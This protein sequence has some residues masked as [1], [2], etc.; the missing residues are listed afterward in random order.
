MVETPGAYIPMD[1]LH[2]LV[3]GRL[4][5]DRTEG[6]ALFADISGFTALTEALVRELGPQRGAEELSRHLNSVYDALINTLHTYGGS[7][8]SFS[9]DAITCWFDKLL[10]T[11]DEALSAAMQVEQN[12][13]GATLR[14]TAC[15]LEMQAAMW[16]FRAVPIPSQQ[17]VALAMKAT[18]A[19]GSVRRFQIGDSK[20]QLIDAL[21]GALL[22]YLA[23]AEHLAQKGEVLL[24]QDAATLIADAIA[25]TEWRED[26]EEQRRSAVVQRLTT[27]VAPTPWPAIPTEQLSENLVRPW[28]LP[29][30]YERLT[31]GESTFLAELRPAVALFIRFTG[32]DYDN[33]DFAGFKLDSFILWVQRIL[34]RYE[35]YLLQLTIGDKGSYLCTV[36]GAPIAHED[37]AVRAISA[38]LDLQALTL[39]AIG[40][41]QI[42]I[43]TGQ[44]RTGAYGG[45]TRR[46]YGILGDD[47][48]LAARLMQAANGGHI[49]TSRAIYQAAPDEFRWEP[50]PPIAV[51]GK[52]EPIAIFSPTG[53]RER[54]SLL[55]I[56]GRY[57]LA[58]VGRLAELALIGERLAAVQ[59]QH[60]QLIGI[61]AEA[62][63]GKSRLVAEAIRL[64]QLRLFHGFGG[65]CESY[66]TTTSY[67]VWRSIWRGFFGV[68]PERSMQEQIENVAQHL[69]NLDAALLPR[70]PLLGAVLNIPIRDNELTSSFDA[71]LRKMSLEGLLVDAL[72]AYLREQTIPLLLV[73]EDCQWMD[74]LS[75]DLLEVIGRAIT[76]LPVLIIMAY[77]PADTPNRPEVPIQ[78]L[79]YF[80]ELALTEFTP[81][82]SAQLI[83]LKL[84]RLFGLTTAPPAALVTNLTQRTQGNPFYIEELLNYLHDRNIDPQNTAALARLELPNSLQSL[85]LSRIDQLNEDHRVTLRIASVIGRLFTS[86]VLW[87]VHPT[88]TSQEHVQL[89]LL[90]LTNSE[91]ILPDAEPELTYLFKHVV[92]QEVAYESLPYATRAH[93]HEQIGDFL[94]S[95]YA[96]TPDQ[97]VY[98]LAHHYGRSENEV[99]QRRYFLRAGEL[100]Q[101]DYNNQAA[102]AYFER[103]LPL[104]PEAEQSEVLLKLGRV[105]ELVGQW[106]AAQARYQAALDR[107]TEQA[108]V[109]LVAQCQATIGELQRKRGNYN[110]AADWQAQAQLVFDSIHDRAGVAQTLHYQGTLAAQQGHFEA[111]N[112][113]YSASL[114]IRREL[115]DQS[116]IASLLS[117]MG[118]VARYQGNYAEARHLH[119]EALVIRRTIGD[120]H[121]ISNSLGNLGNV[122]LDQQ[123]YAAARRL[124]EETLAIA[125]LIGN[126]WSVAIS[127]NNLANVARAQHDVR[128]A[129]EMYIESLAIN[130]D[131]GDQ[132]AFAYLLEDIAGLEALEGQ[133]ERALQLVGAAAVVREAIGAPLSGAERTKLDQLIAPAHQALGAVAAEAALATG[134]TLS[135]LQVHTEVRR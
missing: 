56:E 124:Q 52:R 114:T 35:G 133:A 118:I 134:R 96:Q 21:A 28:L 66:G 103:V 123:D 76:G 49:L 33:D 54:Q 126:R 46:T 47:V 90:E 38:A 74:P 8:I 73:L 42:G 122:A 37:D 18:V 13:R 107:A 57:T 94:L 79:P 45:T 2:A 60:G 64:A 36:F 9:G 17:T 72:R 104:L 106:D 130:R 62:G 24:D 7:V 50:L 93:I 112:R 27:T 65:A 12:T 113:L 58:M 40:K 97:V 70:L 34:A 110:E 95:T 115:D 82:E 25:I 102:I 29:P 89:E 11:S 125:R 88:P 91:L 99:M 109:Q 132:W 14:A 71:R 22:A 77:R 43:S 23:G 32:I 19:A 119:E 41:I 4:L 81:A 5:P 26:T 101:A 10:P 16:A 121:A 85:I 31:V 15:A 128:A 44:M 59:Q 48:N 116:Q 86:A 39:E 69:G 120:R 67:L 30:V 111:A 83:A 78:A 80:T 108:K 68:D 105:L 117:N 100:A 135:A 129:R 20:I 6:A 3:R 131:L 61:C 87:G 92:T 127:L 63:M 51:K 1:R 55:Y 75:R 84:E 98:L 53:R